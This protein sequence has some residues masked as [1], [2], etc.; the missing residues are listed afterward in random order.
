M[1]DALNARRAF[2]LLSGEIHA[3][4]AGT[5]LEDSRF[6]RNAVTGRLQSIG[7]T[8]AIFAPRLA[9]LNFAEDGADAETASL[10]FDDD[11]LGYAPQK[12]KRVRDT[13]DRALPMKAQPAAPGRVFA[14]WGQAFG[15]WGSSDGDG[16]AAAL[17]RSTGGFI[18]GLDVTF[19]GG[20]GGDVWRAGLAGGYQYTS[21]NV[22][23][24]SSSG[25]IDTYHLA[26]YG[27]RQI[28]PLGLRA[29]ASYGWHDISTSR[30]IVF[31]G[32]S[33]TTKA[34][35]DAGTA[36]VFG[37][38]GYALT[39]RQ[40]ALEPFAGL[41]YVSVRTA[42]FTEAGGA[43]TLTG[44]GG[45]SDTTSFD[46]RLACGFCVA[47]ARSLGSHRQGI[48]GLASR[49]RH[50]DAD[51]AAWV[52]VGDDAVRGCRNADRARR[53]RDRAGTGGRRRARRNARRRLHRT[54]GRP[55]GRSRH[56][57]QLRPAVLKKTNQCRS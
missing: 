41:A 36:Q 50:G 25:R 53:R 16:N 29:G 42:G 7:G 31:P 13:M 39:Y 37:E 3:S 57:R 54:S 35:Y 38:I 33:D 48:G 8:A 14:A 21:I 47:L 34:N 27:G 23:D 10:M 26:A 32:F 15:S 45:T 22:G 28:G 5:M 4:I 46:A 18:T 11:A 2:D 19:P 12:R 20:R 9:A 44:A 51:R 43:A 40:F 55:C 56:H 24:R 17:S 30:S 1:L 6:I 52:C 49:V